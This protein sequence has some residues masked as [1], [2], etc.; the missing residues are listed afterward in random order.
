MFQR[1]F[2]ALLVTFLAVPVWSVPVVLSD[3]LSE[4]TLGVI[5]VESTLREAQQFSTGSQ[6]GFL[7]EAILPMVERTAGEAIIDIYTSR[8]NLPGTLVGSLLSAGGGYSTDEFSPAF[9]TFSGN[10]VLTANSAYFA[11]IRAAS[12]E[13]GWAFTDSISGSGAGFSTLSASSINSGASWTP[14]N[15]EPYQMRLTLENGQV[16]ELDGA[17]APLALSLMAGMLLALRRKDYLSSRA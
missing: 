5:Y 3:N 11:V 17:T 16:P 15:L 4:D 12:G 13:Y 1:L 7:V 10:V 14:F 6:A 8:A 2:P 9:H